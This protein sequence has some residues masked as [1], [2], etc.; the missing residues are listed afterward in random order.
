MLLMV[1]AGGVSNVRP[2]NP[3]QMT[4]R[5]WLILIFYWVDDS[6]VTKAAK[7]TEVSEHTA[8]DAL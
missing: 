2:P 1:F 5:E 3:S 8:I 4:L 6:P 7:H